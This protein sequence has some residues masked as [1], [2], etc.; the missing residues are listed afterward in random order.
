MPLFTD[1]ALLV[2]ARSV[3]EL[4]ER[5]GIDRATLGFLEDSPIAVLRDELGDRATRALV[6]IL[7]RIA[8]ADADFLGASL[9]PWRQLPSGESVVVWSS[10]ER[11][12]YQVA[13]FE[14]GPRRI[15]ADYTD[16]RWVKR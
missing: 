12:S 10:E 9:R 1:G 5:L 13:D 15:L 3:D 11:Q 14:E 2:R 6:V 7:R 16:G 8:P 4:A